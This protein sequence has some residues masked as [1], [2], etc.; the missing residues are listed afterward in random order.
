MTLAEIEAQARQ[1]GWPEE[2]IPFLALCCTP[3]VDLHLV[4]ERPLAATGSRFGG[5]PCVPPDFSW[6]VHPAGRYRFLGQINF[7]EVAAPATGLPTSGLLVLFHAEDEDGEV[8]WQDPGYVV[9]YHWDDLASHA[10]LQPPADIPTV[11]GIALDLVP[12]LN[13]PRHEELRNDWPFAT[14]P[15]LAWDLAQAVNADAYL[16]GHPAHC[17]LA[18]DPTPGPGW[19]SLLNV[20]SL[21]ELQ[22]CW[23]DED[24][25]MVFIQAAQ[26]A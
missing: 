4:P 17:S 20:P 7:G 5:S 11:P 9:G 14:A 1:L 25:L 21:P 10:T 19:V 3:C 24:R 23:H 15:D 16:L 6:P 8:S 18:Y 26:L 2:H 22:W 13:V 12:G